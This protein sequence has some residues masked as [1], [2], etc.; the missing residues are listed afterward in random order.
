MTDNDLKNTKW[1]TGLEDIG[2]NLTIKLESAKPIK[3]IFVP[4]YNVLL[5]TMNPELT[6]DYIDERDR[7]SANY[8]LV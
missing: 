7:E 4:Y 6:D 5:Y 2:D 3:T 8:K 1:A